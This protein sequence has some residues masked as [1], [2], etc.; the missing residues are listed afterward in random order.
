MPSI[1]PQSTINVWAD[2]GGTFTDCLVNLPDPSGTSTSQIQRSI[3]VLSSGLVTAVVRSVNS[4]SLTVEMP[5]K[6]VHDHFWTGAQLV[7]QSGTRIG[8]IKNCHLDTRLQS[9]NTAPENPPAHEVTQ[10]HLSLDGVISDSVCTG[11]T[12]TLDGG[13]EAPVL[14][15]RLLLQVPLSQRLPK[16]NARLGTTRGTNALLT[17]SGS[18]LALLI[19]EGFGDLLHIGTQD[20]PD[21]FAL[22]IVK[23]EPLPNTIIEIPGRLTAQG[24]ELIPLDKAVISQR[25][26]ELAESDD[27]PEVIAI[28]LLHAYQNDAHEQAVAQLAHEAGFQRVIRSCQIAALPRI[29]PRAETTTLDAYLQPV[30]EDYVQRV[31]QQFGGERCNL[32]WMTSNGTLVSSGSFRGRESVLS[33]PAGG[34][35]AL[36]QISRQLGLAGAVGLDMGGTSTDVSRFDGQLGRRQESQIAGIRILAPMMDI[37]TVAAGGGSICGVRDGRLFVGPESAG[38]NPGPACYGRGGPLTITDINV[39]LGRLPIDRF[40]FPLDSD[41]SHA[42]LQTVFDQLPPATATSPQTLAAGFLKIAVTEMAEAARVVTT[43]AGNDVR[44]MSLVG[45]GG[46]AGGHLCQVAEAL[47]MHHAVDHSQAG[48]LSAVGIGHAPIGRIITKPL[49]A[50]IAPPLGPETSLPQNTARALIPE[51]LDR[52]DAMAVSLKE[53]CTQ[54]LLTE[55]RI[56][57]N[58]LVEGELHTTLTADLRYLGTQS[59]LEIT[60]H[61]LATLADRMDSKHQETFGYARHT[62]PIEVVAVRCES[63]IIAANNATTPAP[64]SDNAAPTEISFPS[65]PSQPTFD[66]ETLSPGTRIEGPAIIASAHSILVVETNWTATL[67]TNRLIQLH[68]TPLASNQSLP[69]SSKALTA[70]TPK[71][72]DL[73]PPSSTIHPPS[74]RVEQSEGRVAHNS[75]HPSLPVSGKAR[76]AGTPASPSTP[77]PHRSNNDAVEMEVVARRVQGIAEAMG[78]AIRRTS[79]SVNVKE[80]RDYSCAVFLSDGS[81]VA[82]APHVPVHLGAMGHTVRTIIQAFPDMQPGD[83]FISNDPYAGGSHLPDITVVTPVFCS[84]DDGD[85]DLPNRCNFFVASRCHHAEIGGLVPGSMAPNATCLTDE[86]V[87]LSS[88]PLVYLGNTYHADIRHRLQSARYPSRNVDENMADIAAAEAAGREGVRLLQ[89]LADSISPPRLTRLLERLLNVAGQ[90]TATWIESLGNETRQFADQLDDGTPVQVQLVPDPSTRRLKIDFT[91]T[92]DVHPHAFNATRSIVTAAVLY[93]L[94][95]VTPNELPLCDGVLDR[96]DLI[97]PPGLLA[98]PVSRD[99]QGQLNTD[100][101]PAVVAGNVETSNRVVDVLL[102]ALGA[103]AASQGTMNNLLIGDDT[104]GYYETIGGGSGATT[105]APGADAVHT[106]MTNTR[107]TDPE[108]FESRLPLRL[109]KFGIRHGSGGQGKHNGGNG[110]IREIEFLRPL[111]V[112]MITSRRTTTPYGLSGG[113]NGHPGQQTWIHNNNETNLNA[114]FTLSVHPTHR[115]RIQTPGGGG[116]GPQ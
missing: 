106:H 100:D 88:L 40:P 91:G 26:R 21:L 53:D 15:T 110:I 115:L 51:V 71:A 41:A 97:I 38:A 4:D 1:K 58:R 108:I 99:E 22:D 60:I 79:V 76:A 64:N 90:A 102:G 7:T 47:N 43:A 9:Q 101:C 74:G 52:L 72:S 98:P 89:S 19:T 85:P 39:I 25:L 12:L 112:S 28:C 70:G 73:P 29:V 75:S 14:A 55:E 46:A 59:T 84:S 35:V 109:W 80:R 92:G 83:C 87:V 18:S 116:Y 50:T 114:S 78:E 23:P 36:E 105:N 8:Q 96:I 37:H 24:E 20:R 54:R 48:I 32:R 81:L 49:L 113:T 2:I 3:K 103:A 34:V 44:K 11:D 66:R 77:P 69:L 61:P 56:D 5:T 68:R 104:F 33:G 67:D 95:C 86:G 42:A 27:R 45:F 31:T 93:V 6:F 16:L 13:V 94:R 17:R 82:N 111:T 107:I 10:V 65:D 63:K 57:T 62:M 30:L